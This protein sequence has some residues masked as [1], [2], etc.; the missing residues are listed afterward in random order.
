MA[1]SPRTQQQQQQQHS[2]HTSAGT[3]MSGENSVGIAQQEQQ[4]RSTP[5]Q[6]AEGGDSS[7]PT[8]RRSPSNDSLQGPGIGRLAQQLDSDA[9]DYFIDLFQSQP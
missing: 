2:V 3:S 8:T 5:V 4:T 9:M 6:G 7:D 1:V